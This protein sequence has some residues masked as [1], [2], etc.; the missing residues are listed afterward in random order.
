MDG[1]GIERIFG[2]SAPLD[3]LATGGG[4]EPKAAKKLVQRTGAPGPGR[5][6]LNSPDFA[7]RQAIASCLFKS[8]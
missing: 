8:M 7:Q 6:G 3:G 4:G 2:A 1:P 5:S